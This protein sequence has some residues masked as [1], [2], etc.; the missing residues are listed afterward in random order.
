MEEPSLALERPAAK[1]TLDKAFVHV[2][3]VYIYTHICVY[4]YTYIGRHSQ[5]L[6]AKRPVKFL[7]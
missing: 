2:E 4:T 1:C 7:A 3:Y 5:S 6:F